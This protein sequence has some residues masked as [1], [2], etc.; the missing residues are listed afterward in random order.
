MQKVFSKEFFTELA[1]ECSLNADELRLLGKFRNHEI[2]V[3]GDTYDMLVRVQDQFERLEAM[4]DDEYRGFYIEVPRPTL[5]EWGDCD[6]LIEAGECD[7][8]EDY[9][10]E[11]EFW[12]PMGMGVLESHGD[13]LVL[14]RIVQV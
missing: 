8:R 11:W 7:S 9:I 3:D 10:R 1:R 5:D 6:E 2:L 14:C 12:N 13:P 4:G